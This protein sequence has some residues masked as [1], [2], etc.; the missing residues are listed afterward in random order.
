M[1]RYEDVSSITRLSAEK[2]RLQHVQAL[3][4]PLRRF[5]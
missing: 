3:L 4:M 2:L 1:P 5:C